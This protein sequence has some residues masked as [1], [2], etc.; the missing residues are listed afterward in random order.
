MK[1]YNTEQ[2]SP[3]WEQLRKTH[4]TGTALKGIMGTPRARQE[5][6]YEVIADRLTVG[7]ESDEEY[8]N[9]MARGTRLEPDAIAEFEFATGKKVERVGFCE[10]DDIKEVA[11]SPDGYIADTNDTEAIEI[12][13]MGGKN[14]VKLWLTN[15]VPD[16]YYWQVIQYFVVNDK[17][18]KLYFVGFNPQIPVH[19]LHIIEVKRE[20]LESDIKKAKESQKVFLQ[21][22][23]SILLTLIKI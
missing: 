8:E 17:L 6:I 1:K 7:V 22:I 9:P 20:N 4:I 12:K 18:E 19:S 2:R 13:S 3:E 21:E 15:E 23:E 16:E 11:Q 14:H 10:S 5:A